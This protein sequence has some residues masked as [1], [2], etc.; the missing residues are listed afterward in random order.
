MGGSALQCKVASHWQAHTQNDPMSWDPKNLN[1]QIW[2]CSMWVYT[3]IGIRVHVTHM[4]RHNGLM[5]LL[6]FQSVV[7][8]RGH[9]ATTICISIWLHHWWERE[10]ICLSCI[11]VCAVCERV[12]AFIY[13]YIYMHMCTCGGFCMWR[14]D[15]VVEF[16]CFILF[17]FSCC[18]VDEMIPGRSGI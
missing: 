14:Q 11:S 9:L 3:C 6:F 15:Y 8:N 2:L 18:A 17:C 16:F 1:V 4:Q 12:Y 5:I 13:I 10:N 7:V